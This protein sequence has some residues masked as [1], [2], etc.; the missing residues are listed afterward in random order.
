MKCVLFWL[1]SLSLSVHVLSLAR[2]PRTVLLRVSLFIVVVPS[3][4]SIH[5]FFLSR[6]R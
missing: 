2:F 1:V 4:Y 5:L 3:S 6:V